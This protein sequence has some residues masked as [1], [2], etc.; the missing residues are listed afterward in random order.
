LISLELVTTPS[1]GLREM[2]RSRMWRRTQQT[3]E[4][5]EAIVQ[6]ET[7]GLIQGMLVEMMAAADIAEKA[8]PVRA[9]ELVGLC[10][11]HFSLLALFGDLD[12]VT[13]ALE[14]ITQQL[15]PVEWLRRDRKGQVTPE[16]RAR[17]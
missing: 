9:F 7:I 15:K 16:V 1:E 14:A 12:A 17:L 11:Q 13:T 3:R 2:I 5:S 4:E 8:A 10:P 6:S